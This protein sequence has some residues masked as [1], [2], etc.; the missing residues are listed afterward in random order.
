MKDV[1]PDKGVHKRT[2]SD[3]WQ[4]RVFVPKDV[5]TFYGG[6]AVLP[7]R[8]LATKDLDKANSRARLRVAEFEQE[9][10]Q[11][12]KAVFASPSTAVNGGPALT[13]AVIERLASSHRSQVLDRDF[14]KRV[15]AYAA[16]AADRDAFWRGETI[17]LPRPWKVRHSGWSHWDVLRTDADTPLETGVAFCLNAQRKHRLDTLKDALRVG[18]AS[19]VASAAAEHLVSH[20]HDDA[21]RLKLVRRLLEAEIDAL[22]NILKEEVQHFPDVFSDKPAPQ[23]DAKENPL[24]SVAVGPWLEEKKSVDVDG[25]RVED[26]EAAVALLTEVVG[27]KPMAAYTKGDVRELKDILRALP[28]NRNKIKETRGLGVLAKRLGLAPL[29]TKTANKY[30]GVLY[31]LFEFAVGNYDAVD[32]NPFQNAALATRTSPREEW[33]PYSLDALRKF[34]G[35]PLYRGCKSAKYWL[36]PGTE[37]PR[38]SARFWLPLLLLYSGARVNEMCKL[39]SG[40][41]GCEEGVHFFNIVWEEDEEGVSRRVKNSSSVRKV[42]VHADLI[43]FGFLEFVQRRKAAKD[44]RLFPELKPDRYGK[45]FSGISK[46]FSDT[47]LPNLG[48]KTKKTSLKSFRHTF[49]DAAHNSRIPEEIIQALKGDTAGGTIG[50]YG[51]GKTDLEILT[52]EMKKLRFKGLDLSHLES[53]AK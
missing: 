15:Q 2:G 23:S 47:Y 36:K 38:D 30:L 46:R 18:H 43:S 32:R 25:R 8:S 29:S 34:F 26:C 50:R 22:T 37:I 42:P 17:P 20:A 1:R 14:E 40:D 33:D 24:L 12:R 27:D 10:A 39:G 28:A 51:H 3:V 5:R 49:V 21:G 48:I 11:K 19:L 13:A 6:K 41:V 35:S 16:A 53:F 45:L 7:A 31:N 4:H 52:E 44:G 9:F